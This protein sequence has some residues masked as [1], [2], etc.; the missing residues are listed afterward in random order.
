M[1]KIKEKNYFKEKLALH[2]NKIKEANLIAKEL[3]R[4]VYFEIKLGYS[5][6]STT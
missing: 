3:K 4:N 5:F 1:Y 2:L 6:T